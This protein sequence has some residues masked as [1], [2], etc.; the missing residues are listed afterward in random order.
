MPNICLSGGA[1]PNRAAS[2]SC[3]KWDSLCYSRFQTANTPL[4]WAG[5]L[6]NTCPN[7]ISTIIYRYCLHLHLS[8]KFP[9]ATHQ[10][11][12]QFQQGCWVT[13]L[14]R[15]LPSLRAAESSPRAPDS[16][17]F[18]SLNTSRLAHSNLHTGAVSCQATSVSRGLR[19]HPW[20]LSG[21]LPWH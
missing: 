9:S 11:V 2:L 10:R 6:R 8:Y 13:A 1:V 17:G 18:T 12:R 7:A 19:Q 21:G 15:V 5:Q 16:G 4:V 20:A 14:T 3:W